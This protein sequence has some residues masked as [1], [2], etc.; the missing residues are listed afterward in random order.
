MSKQSTTVFSLDGLLSSQSL[1]IKIQVQM[2]L[3]DWIKVNRQRYSLS[4]A[5]AACEDFLENPPKPHYA[6]NMPISFHPEVEGLISQIQEAFDAKLIDL[7]EIKAYAKALDAEVT[8]A[9]DA[10]MALEDKG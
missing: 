3:D 6:G 4:K 5:Y 1:S 10:N 9:L 2:V 8:K 7:D